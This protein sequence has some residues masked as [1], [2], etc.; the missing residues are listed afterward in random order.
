MILE[1]AFTFNDNVAKIGLLREQNSMIFRVKLS[2][3]LMAKIVMEVKND[4]IIKMTI[5][6]SEG[7]K[8]IEETS[9]QFKLSKDLYNLAFKWNPETFKAVIRAVQNMIQ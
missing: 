2:P 6:R 7:D 4:N 3:I 5:Q 9:M 8:L 1:N